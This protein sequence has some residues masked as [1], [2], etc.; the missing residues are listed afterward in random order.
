MWLGVTKAFAGIQFSASIKTYP[1]LR[2]KTKKQ[3]KK[4]KKKKKI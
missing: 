4:K 3:K 2:V 1:Y